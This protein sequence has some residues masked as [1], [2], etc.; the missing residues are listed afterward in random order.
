MVNVL[1]RNA[2]SAEESLVLVTYQAWKAMIRDIK[3]SLALEA[4]E[5][6]IKNMSEEHRQDAEEK[7]KEKEKMEKE[8]KRVEAEKERLEEQLREAKD[9]VEKLKE[10]HKE[11]NLSRMTGGNKKEL[12][13]T[14][15]AEWAK[16]MQD[17]VIIRAEEEAE[18]EVRLRLGAFTDGYKFRCV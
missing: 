17:I 10:L 5:E 3:N 1:G 2:A 18:N 7:V 14:I 4:E 13:K 6:M 9:R 8:L 16:Y 11:S 12:V 15:F